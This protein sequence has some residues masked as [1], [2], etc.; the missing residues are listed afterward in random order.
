MLLVVDRRRDDL[1]GIGNRTQQANA[2]KSVPF[3]RFGD[4]FDLRT[5]RVELRDPRADNTKAEAWAA[6][7]ER[8]QSQWQT[9]TWRGVA[10]AGLFV[11]ATK[12][13]GAS[14]QRTEQAF[15]SGASVGE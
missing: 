12:A 5:Q 8:G 14:F 10:Q 1:A 3:G 13:I 9:Y 15:A 4:R 7:D 2:R 11:C 6:S